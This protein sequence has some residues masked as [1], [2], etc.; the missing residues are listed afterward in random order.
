MNMLAVVGVAAGYAPGSG[1]FL[2][3]SFA[4]FLFI[5]GG[6]S[7]GIAAFLIHKAP[8][9]TPARARRRR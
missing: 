6:V 9:Y 4:L 8:K 7:M 3:D 1:A 5:A 2:S